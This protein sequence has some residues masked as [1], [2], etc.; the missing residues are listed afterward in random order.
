MKLLGA[1]PPPSH[2]QQQLDCTSALRI[3]G[4]AAGE[5]TVHLA[6]ETLP[7]PITP[8]CYHLVVIDRCDSTETWIEVDVS[9]REQGELCTEISPEFL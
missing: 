8:F 9:N 4:C 6:Q 7:L 5:G 1:A 3:A 2:Q